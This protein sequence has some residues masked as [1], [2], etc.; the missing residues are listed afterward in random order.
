MYL[1]FLDNNFL[2]FCIYFIL[3]VCEAEL[4]VKGDA[5]QTCGLHLTQRQ[6][7]SAKSLIFITAFQPKSIQYFWIVSQMD[8]QSD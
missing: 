1:F 7:S 5:L 3:L 4:A 2:Y 6:N 8:S